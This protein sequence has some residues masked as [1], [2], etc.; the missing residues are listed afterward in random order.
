M[1]SR[2]KTTAEAYQQTTNC[3]VAACRNHCTNIRA[4]LA[5]LYSTSIIQLLWSSIFSRFGSAMVRGRHC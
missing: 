4:L 1:L 5:L 2:A 3:T